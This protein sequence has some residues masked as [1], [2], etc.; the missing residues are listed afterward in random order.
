MGTL[1]PIQINRDLYYFSD[2]ASKFTLADD[3]FLLLGDNVP[4]SIDSRNWDEPAIPRKQIL[5]T[6]E[7]ESPKKMNNP[8]LP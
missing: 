1:G 7:L 2:H 4:I 6:L 5:G 8:Q 3:E